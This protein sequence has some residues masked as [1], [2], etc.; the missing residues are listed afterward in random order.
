MSELVTADVFNRL[1]ERYQNRARQIAARVA[2]IEAVLTRGQ[3]SAIR[4]AVLRLRGQLRPQPDTALTE[5]AGEF[6]LACSDLPE[7]AI[8]E[9]TNDYLAGRVENHTGQYMPTCAEFARYARSIIRSFIAER[10]SLKNE[11]ERLLQRAED[12]TRRIRIKTERADPKL[13]ERVA[14]LAK[15]VRT[16]AAKV[17]TGQR[18]QGTTDEMREKMDALRRPCAVQPSRLLETRVV[19]GARK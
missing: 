12:E 8:S 2:E 16:G 7:W 4:D 13:K 1:P 6:R 14:K 10:A 15:S 3:P 9:A 5:V 19:K 17:H 18:H 11:A